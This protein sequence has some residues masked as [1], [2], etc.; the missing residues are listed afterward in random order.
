MCAAQPALVPGIKA[1]STT[2]CF[3][4]SA[5][6]QKAGAANQHTAGMDP[7]FSFVRR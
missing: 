5:G 4:L 3:N 1:R 2:A 6:K 7:A